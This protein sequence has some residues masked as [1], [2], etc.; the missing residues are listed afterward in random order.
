MEGAAE[1][2]KV[3][4]LFTVAKLED[5]FSLL[6][7]D[8]PDRNK[9]LITT[10]VSDLPVEMVETGSMVIGEPSLPFALYPDDQSR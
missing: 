3:I 4:L 10:V 7:G 5:G 1:I 6:D 2:F 8:C 9:E